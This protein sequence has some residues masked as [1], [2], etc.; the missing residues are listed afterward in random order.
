MKKRGF[1]L[2]EIIIAVAIFGIISVGI[3]NFSQQSQSMFKNSSTRYEIQ[4][5]VIYTS[6]SF[7]EA[8]RES[9]ANFLLNKSKYDPAN[10]V[11]KADGSLDVA[12]L[13]LSE[14]WNYIGLNHDS[15]RI[16]KFIWDKATSTHI[17][18][19]LTLS[20]K[21]NSKHKIEYAM[22]LNHGQKE[23]LEKIQALKLKSPMTSEDKNQLKI[24]ENAAKDN[25][26][27]LQYTISG[28]IVDDKGN[29]LDGKPANE[30]STSS[31]VEAVNT[32]QVIDRSEGKTV[33]AIAY[34][35]TPLNTNSS[36]KVRPAIVLVL[37]F[38]G[39]MNYGMD[40]NKNP[41]DVDRRVTLLKR[42]YTELL[43]GFAKMGDVELYVVP[44]SNYSFSSE[45]YTGNLAANQPF[46]IKA[47]SAGDDSELK[48]AQ[49]AL[50]GLR[51]LSGTNY[52]DGLRVGL[53]YLENASSSRTYMLVLSDGQPSF[54]NGYFYGNNFHR[55]NTS[56]FISGYFNG[57]NAK[58]N[59]NND[60][61]R[62]LEFVKQIANRNIHQPRLIHLIGF[63]SVPEDNKQLNTI[64]KY[65]EVGMKMP[66]ESVVTYSAESEQGLGDAFSAFANEIE[67]DLWY[68]DGP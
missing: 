11:E 20:E 37:D 27:V 7:N 28:K 23:I 45:N 3:T 48:R 36:E 44:F 65:L 52:G 62:G 6:N 59:M 46:N 43:N 2:M 17:P 41:R 12:P 29:L 32:K 30:Y 16:Y 9:T 33:T 5:D 53:N 4:T 64:K 50:N 22:T 47:T 34:R 49:S 26:S 60:F 66:S 38:S 42:K 57:Y 31:M 35:N 67:H 19:E 54:Y 21:G 14:E 13:N 1:T 8:V 63:S 55:Y 24:L 39:S 10:V 61:A 18:I 40:G 56:D 58:Q 68:F 15:S 51:A 25:R